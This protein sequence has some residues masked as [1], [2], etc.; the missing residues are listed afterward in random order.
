[1]P[2]VANVTYI[3]EAHALEQA[4][5]AFSDYLVIDAKTRQLIA[6]GQM[7]DALALN[8]GTQPGQSD[9]AFSRFS[10]AMEEDR[11]INRRV[12]DAT[13]NTEQNALTYNRLLFGV[14]SCVLL[15]VLISAVCITAITSC[16]RNRRDASQ[17]PI[18]GCIT[19]ST[20]NAL[21]N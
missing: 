11:A 8:T 20:F 4:R 5:K 13:W 14:V 17:A 10:S 1:M 15:I 6:S 7:A 19:E 18:Y 2:L 12:F 3:G 21:F 16:K 9:E